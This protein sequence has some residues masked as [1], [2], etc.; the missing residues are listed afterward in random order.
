MT[1]AFRS[2]PAGVVNTD[3]AAADFLVHLQSKVSDG[4]LRSIKD[5]LLLGTRDQY[6]DRA[7]L[8]VAVEHVRQD[9]FWSDIYCIS[10]RVECHETE[11]LRRGMSSHVELRHSYVASRSVLRSKPPTWGSSARTQKLR[12]PLH[13]RSPKISTTQAIFSTAIWSARSRPVART[14]SKYPRS[15]KIR[16]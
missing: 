14:R 15:A 13:P 1:P 3:T 12:S 8:D 5:K 2:L 11:V 9:R 10:E 6:L 4:V 16:L 7:T